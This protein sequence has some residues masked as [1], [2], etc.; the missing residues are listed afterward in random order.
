MLWLDYNPPGVDINVWKTSMAHLNGELSITIH[1]HTLP[2]LRHCERNQAMLVSCYCGG[3]STPL[4]CR[5]LLD[6]RWLKRSKI[7]RQFKMHVSICSNDSSWPYWS[8]YLVTVSSGF[9]LSDG[10]RATLQRLTHI[11]ISSHCSSLRLPVS[12]SQPI[13]MQ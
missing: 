9:D 4:A 8:I 3:K 7:S 5:S 1:S 6:W 2:V 13:T 12:S 10:T 11:S